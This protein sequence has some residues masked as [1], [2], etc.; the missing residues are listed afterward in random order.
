MRLHCTA[1]MRM[2]SSVPPMASF[3]KS[4]TQIDNSRSTPPFEQ[5]QS[6][7]F[8]LLLVKERIRLL[9]SDCRPSFKVENQIW[10]SKTDGL[11]GRRSPWG[12]DV[13]AYVDVSRAIHWLYAVYSTLS[14]LTD[15]S[16]YLIYHCVSSRDLETFVMWKKKKGNVLC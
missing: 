9:V 2:C 8:P 6:F 11:N 15:A 16:F 13:L 5:V 1:G 4:Y 3:L 10:Y 12:S 7:S 14:K